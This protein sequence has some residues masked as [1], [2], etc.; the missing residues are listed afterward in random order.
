MIN[1]YADRAKQIKTKAVVNE[2]PTEKLLRELKEENDRLK[3]AVTS[4]KINPDDFVDEDGDGIN[5]KDMDKMRSKWEE[6]VK[7]RML[8]NEREM[9]EMKKTYEEK[10]KSQKKSLGVSNILLNCSPVCCH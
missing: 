6:E 2:D 1:R 8:D 5:D 10:M 3:K 9:I 4:G 7:A